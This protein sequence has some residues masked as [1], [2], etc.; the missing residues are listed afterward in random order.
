MKKVISI[1]L[2]GILSVSLCIGLTGCS[3]IGT[4]YTL[5]EAYG[6]G[7]LTQ[8]DLLSIAYYQNGDRERNEELMAEDYTPEPQ[9]EMSEEISQAILRTAAREWRNDGSS[10]VQHVNA[11]DFAIVRYYGAYRECY[12]V[13]LTETFIS[14]PAVV[15]DVWEEVGGVWFHYANFLEISVWRQNG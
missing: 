12:V 15:N 9:Q 4:F 13:M 5:D 1:L 10:S 8:A 2:A 3:P 7:L 14:Y 11:D 6:E